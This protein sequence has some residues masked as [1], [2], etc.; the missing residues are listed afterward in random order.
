MQDSLRYPSILWSTLIGLL[1][2][3]VFSVPLTCIVCLKHL[4]W[5]ACGA[6][7]KEN[8]I[9]LFRPL[10]YAHCHRLHRNHHVSCTDMNV[11]WLQEPHNQQPPPEFL[12]SLN[13]LSG[14]VGCFVGVDLCSL[15]E[16]PWRN[17]N[18]FPYPT[19]M[20]CFVA[21]EFL[22][23]ISIILF[24]RYFR[25]TFTSKGLKWHFFLKLRYWVRSIVLVTDFFFRS[26]SLVGL[27]QEKGP[28][29]TLKYSKILF[30]IIMSYSCW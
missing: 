16:R 20:L 12:K 24:L 27:F 6:P 3:F 10:C 30:L 13:F 25:A 2:R 21:R 7:H 9:G 23:C 14:W 18:I 22:H 26:V 29:F 28:R 17:P 1:T 19:W 8:N 4:Q 11:S 15:V 5:L